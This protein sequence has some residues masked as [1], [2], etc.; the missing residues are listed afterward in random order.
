MPI[1]QLPDG[2]SVNVPD[3]ASPEVHAQIRAKIQQQVAASGQPAPP[4]S[5]WE[6]AK[7]L[8]SDVARGAG[9][10]LTGMMEGAAAFN[11]TQS[12]FD[13]SKQ[14]YNELTQKVEQQLP[15]PQGDSTSRQYV[16]AGLEGLGG[17]MTTGIPSV[18]G[19]IS[20]V[21]GGLGG[22][23]GKRLG[24]A[25]GQFIGSLAGGVGAGVVAGVASRARPQS[26]ALAKEALEGFSPQEFEA[27]QAFMNKAKAA[28]TDIDLAQA[29]QAVTGREGNLTLLRNAVASRRQG[30]KVNTTLNRQPEQLQREAEMTLAGLPGKLYEK[31]QAANNLQESASARLKQATTERGNEV[32]GLYAKA[33]DIAP[34]AREELISIIRKEADKPGATEVLKSRAGEMIQKLSGKDAGM[35]KAVAAARGELEAATTPGARAAAREKLAAA[36]RILSEAT[37]APLKALDVD[38]WIGELRGPWQG[39]PLKV[40]YPK[41]QGQ[42]KGLAGTLNKRFQE[43]SPEVAAAE[44]RFQQITQDVINPLKQGPIG[45]LA[46]AHGYDPATGAQISKLDG[47]LREGTEI[48]SPHSA[49]RTAV[50]ELAKVSDTAADEALK[51]NL[52]VRI[53]SALD[54]PVTEGGPST[55]TD[56]ADRL[57]KGLFK[58][59]RQW[60]GLKDFIAESS[61]VKGADPTDVIRGMENLKQITHAMTSRP[62]AGGGLSGED[63]KR[64]GGSS[65]TANVVRIASFLPANRAGEMIER[66]TLGK[67]LSQ[68]DA[69]L[70]SPEGVKMLME[71]GRV[72]VMS[73]KAQVILGTYGASLGNPPGLMDYNPPE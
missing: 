33:G 15:T 52:N 28:R 73:K 51:A 59:P 32:R 23:A 20:G 2:N 4:Q 1:I 6:M 38:T 35:E 49:I 14:K 3:D 39:Q 65:N 66:A 13:T 30:D 61:K 56:M 43:L 70:T 67:T 40:A 72:P 36:N 53:K 27:A 7:G 60:Q 69:I 18:M 46:Q 37:S 68:F 47:L 9:K 25:P 19:A 48:T 21:G 31:A 26:A 11:D 42:I 63:I 5:L 64:L 29:L 16:R 54:S 62:A 45:R 58:D 17:A 50:R 12:R 22:E 34:D 55:N 24:G 8:G 10:A 41:E 57:Y 71:L 44:A